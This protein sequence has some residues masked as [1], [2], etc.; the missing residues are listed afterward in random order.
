MTH[1][2]YF[3]RSKRFASHAQTGL[4]TTGLM[5]MISTSVQAQVTKRKAPSPPA[6]ELS[7]LERRLAEAKKEEAMMTELIAIEV[8]KVDG[9]NTCT[10][11]KFA[12]VQKS[13][14][15]FI[16]HYAEFEN[17]SHRLD[18]VVGRANQKLASIQNQTIRVN[19]V[20]SQVQKSAEVDLSLATLASY[21]RIYNGRLRSCTPGTE[22]LLREDMEHPENN[23][24]KVA[25]SQVVTAMEKMSINLN[26]SMV[27]V[28][29][30][31]ELN[32]SPGPQGYS[33]E[34][35]VRIKDRAAPKKLYRFS[36]LETNH[37]GNVIKLS[38]SAVWSALT[39]SG[40][41]IDKMPID[42]L[43]RFRQLQAQELQTC[44]P[45]FEIPNLAGEKPF[46]SAKE[47]EAFS[48]NKRNK[49]SSLISDSSTG[50]MYDLNAQEF[51]EL[52]PGTF[53]MGMN[54]YVHVVSLTKAFEIQTTDV[55]QLQYFELMGNNPS[56]HK[57]KTNCPESFVTRGDISMCP[58]HPVENLTWHDAH[59]FIEKMNLRKDGYHYRLP[60][61]A[62]WEYAARGGQVSAGANVSTPPYFFGSD[63]SQLGTFAWYKTN[64]NGET[65]DVALKEPNSLGLYDMLGN[66]YQWVEDSS[67]PLNSS[68]QTDPLLVVASDD[69][70]VARGGAY[71]YDPDALQSGSRNRASA[72]G[73]YPHLGFRLVRTRLP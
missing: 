31:Y 63:V 57:V 53:R 42:G 43:K 3:I 30:S 6:R 25:H 48:K 18:A 2:S 23:H 71:N 26:A 56:K 59:R 41:T 5:L 49:S 22:E 39:R 69:M 34:L 64:S 40:E 70:K 72:S 24:L 67:T 62:E 35:R 32:F 13:D 9:Y 10:R 17:L 36:L 61:E 46:L 8:N 65:H 21:F 16:S 58:N 28:D 14:R 27:A 29:E 68:A 45:D 1:L 55:T 66:V 44:L 33:L 20:Q 60:T 19:S 52:D 11:R 7:Y 38:E 47:V 12:A 4:I 51:V 50:L 15:W 73:A 54:D 37:V